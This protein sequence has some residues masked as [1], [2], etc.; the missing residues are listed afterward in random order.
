M[1]SW[2]GLLPVRSTPTAATLARV[3]DGGDDGCRDFGLGPREQMLGAEPLSLAEHRRPAI[4]GR[5]TTLPASGLATRPGR[6]ECPHSTPSVRPRPAP[7]RAGRAGLARQPGERAR[8]AVGERQR[9][10]VHVVGHA[11]S[12]G[13]RNRMR[14]RVGGLRSAEP[15]ALPRRWDCARARPSRACASLSGPLARDHRVSPQQRAGNGGDARG[16]AP[17]RPLMHSAGRGCACRP[18][19]GATKSGSPGPVPMLISAS[20]R[21]SAGVVRRLPIACRRCAPA[22]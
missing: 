18:A 5:S 19:V 11:T 3:A 9:V 13:F 7:S 15:P 4:D 22:M 16:S 10:L 1:F 12:T 14:D 21:L 2:P 17:T 6:V 8:A 20:S